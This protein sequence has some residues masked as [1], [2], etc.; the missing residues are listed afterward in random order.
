M[1]NDFSS[2]IRDAYF[3]INN[4]NE[5]NLIKDLII[6]CSSTISPI[7]DPGPTIISL[8]DTVDLIV[9]KYGPDWRNYA[10]CKVTV[11]WASS[12]FN[13]DHVKE[14]V[15]DLFDLCIEY[16]KHGTVNGKEIPRNFALLAFSIVDPNY[17]SLDL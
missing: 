16:R 12:N 4:E 6:S 9:K 11:I 3:V 14:I 1:K 8:Q 5:D 10:E 17:N 2:P 15:P 7:E 13:V